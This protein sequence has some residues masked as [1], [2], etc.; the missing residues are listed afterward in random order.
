MS[1][2]WK[3]AVATLVVGAAAVVTYARVKEF[4]W[5]LL[6]SWRMGSL[7]LLVLGLGTCIVVGSGV[8]PTK[9]GW[10]ITATTLGVAAFIFGII[11][12]AINSKL[13]FLALAAGI[14]ALWLLTTL[15]HLITTGA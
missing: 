15:H 3:D 5:P 10:T 12:M 11:G 4:D 14:I 8:V 13:A 7:V 1:L 2:S 9:D 6:T